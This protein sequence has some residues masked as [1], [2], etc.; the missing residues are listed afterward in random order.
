M[1]HMNYLSLHVALSPLQWVDLNR[2]Y[3]LPSNGLMVQMFFYALHISMIPLRAHIHNIT[4][5]F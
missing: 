4:F 1:H 5:I 2:H 3:M